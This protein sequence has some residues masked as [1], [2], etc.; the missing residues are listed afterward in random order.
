VKHSVIF[1]ISDNTELMLRK[2]QSVGKYLQGK[3]YFLIEIRFRF[4]WTEKHCVHDIIK[5]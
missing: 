2:I 1:K 3:M 5:T 4:S